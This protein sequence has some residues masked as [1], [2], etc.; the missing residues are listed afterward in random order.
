MNGRSERVRAALEGVKVR[1]DDR[2]Q[3]RARRVRAEAEERVLAAL[4]ERPLTGSE[5]SR[6]PLRGTVFQ[7][8][9]ARGASLGG[10]IDRGLIVV[11][12]VPR[13]NGGEPVRVFRIADEPQGGGT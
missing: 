5:L 6:G 8:A 10:M 2:S 7:R 13:V 3:E 12:L 1:V 9:A 4:R 11:D